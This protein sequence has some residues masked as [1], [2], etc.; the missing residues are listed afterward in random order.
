MSSL[1]K[2]APA[3]RGLRIQ[4]RLFLGFGLL[5]AMMLTMVVVGFMGL[6]HVSNSNKHLIEVDWV[7]ADAANTLSAIALANGRRTLE[8]LTAPTDAYR[9]QMRADIAG[10]RQAFVQSFKTLT[11]LVQ[12]P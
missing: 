1:S 10:A 12:L 7:K 5:I 4:T 6:T 11:E 8:I 9:A 2:P 3:V